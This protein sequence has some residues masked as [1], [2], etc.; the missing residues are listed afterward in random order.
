MEL[1]EEIKNQYPAA[2]YFDSSWGQDYQQKR[3]V[4]GVKAWWLDERQSMESRNVTNTIGCNDQMKVLW[5]TAG[6]FLFWIKSAKNV[7][8]EGI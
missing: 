4:D 7:E 6:F 8:E 2:S 3:D 1:M 5:S